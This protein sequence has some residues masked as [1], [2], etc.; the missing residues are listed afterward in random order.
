MAFYLVLLL[1]LEIGMIEMQLDKFNKT[2]SRHHSFHRSFVN[3]NGSQQDLKWSHRYR[4][5]E[6]VLF[7]LVSLMFSNML[8]M[9]SYTTSKIKTRPGLINKP[10]TY[11]YSLKF[12]SKA[13]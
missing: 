9:I 3:A 6:N 5:A 7:R 12:C 2:Y 4:L 11:T 8:M 1:A 10:N 13:V